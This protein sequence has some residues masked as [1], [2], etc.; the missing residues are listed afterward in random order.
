MGICSSQIK[1]DKTQRKNV[2]I[3]KKLTLTEQKSFCFKDER[4]WTVN[5]SF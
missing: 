3:E 2:E 5:D 1:E 4:N